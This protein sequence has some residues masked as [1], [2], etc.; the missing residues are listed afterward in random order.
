MKS[1]A[2]I[3]EITPDMT[4]AEKKK[5]EQVAAE[6]RTDALRYER[7]KDR[8][9]VEGVFRF[10]AIPGGSLKFPYRKYKWDPVEVWHFVDGQRYKIP[11][12]VAK[13]LNTNGWY[14]EFEH[15]AGLGVQAGNRVDGS[16]PS[17]RIS[18]KVHRFGFHSLDFTDIA[19][20]N[21]PV[22]EIVQVEYR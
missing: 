7:D 9:L 14:P 19:E 4:L 16:S 5:I 1:S 3:K 10:Y 12:G 11:V 18:R 2:E 20:L 15:V 8:E 21:R 17:V 13:H 22:K 6:K